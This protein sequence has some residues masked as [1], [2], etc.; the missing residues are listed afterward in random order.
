M[1]SGVKCREQPFDFYG[2]R[3]GGGEGDGKGVNG[4]GRCF[5]AWNFFFLKKVILPHKIKR[6]LPK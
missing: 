5:P 6:S 4:W 2:A 3:G 1:N